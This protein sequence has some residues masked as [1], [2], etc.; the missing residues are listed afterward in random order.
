MDIFYRYSYNHRGWVILE[1]R[2]R[3][4]QI[5]F[6]DIVGVKTCSSKCNVTKG[7]RINRIFFVYDF[8]CQDRDRIRIDRNK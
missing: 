1:P 5:S 7:F 3:T 4:T 2:I 8:A 6:F